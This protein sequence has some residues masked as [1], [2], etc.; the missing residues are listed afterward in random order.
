MKCTFTNP[1]NKTFYTNEAGN[2]C[3]TMFYCSLMALP[4]RYSFSDLRKV[5]ECI[6][7]KYHRS[8]LNN[9]NNFF[10]SIYY[11]IVTEAYDYLKDALK[12]DLA[13]FQE[14]LISESDEATAGF[15][16]SELRNQELRVLSDLKSLYSELCLGRPGATIKAAELKKVYCMRR[17]DYYRKQEQKRVQRFYVA[18][19][20]ARNSKLLNVQPNLLESST[21]TTTAQ[22]TELIKETKRNAYFRIHIPFEETFNL[23]ENEGEVYD[24][25]V[26]YQ[27]QK[28]TKKLFLC[29]FCANRNVSYCKFCNNR[30]EY[31]KKQDD[32]VADSAS[33]RISANDLI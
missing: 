29:R 21:I 26:N 22:F 9:Q 31:L 19:D 18:T 17:L 15:H 23:L 7:K 28:E 27:V 25:T 32:L 2:S 6:S 24:R 1:L 5:F 11:T 33:L 14:D 3:H 10:E 13:Q 20:T 8:T 30:T 4:S 12:Q 16:E